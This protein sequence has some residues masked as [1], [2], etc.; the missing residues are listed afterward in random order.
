M[1]APDWHSAPRRVLD[2]RQQITSYCRGR[3]VD[4][5][6]LAMQFAL[7]YDGV[8]TSLMGMSKVRHVDK[9]VKSVGVAPDPEIL[10]EVLQM[11]KPVAN[12]VW[13]EGRPENQDPGAVEP[14]S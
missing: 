1:G 5:A 6:D 4:I 12:V 11:I 3:G 8:V 13:M 9:N 14:G 10:A 2:V 7:Q